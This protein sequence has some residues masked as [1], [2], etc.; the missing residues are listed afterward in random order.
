MPDFRL[1]Q[2]FEMAT[3]NINPYPSRVEK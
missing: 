2:T 1:L 3:T